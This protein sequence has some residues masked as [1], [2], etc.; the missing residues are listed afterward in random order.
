MAVSEDFI[1]RIEDRIAAVG[2]SDRQVSMA[3]TGKPDL[4]RDLKRRGVQP[5]GERL[6]RLAR[7][8]GTTSEWLLRGE[9]V[10][11]RRDLGADLSDPYRVFRH[12]RPRDVPVRGT[13]SCGDIEVDG[14]SVE[15]V[16]MDLGETVDY[17]RRPASLDGRRD[18]YAIYFTGYSM[19]PRFEQGEVA[20]V[21]TKRPPAIGDYVVVQLRAQRCEGDEPRIVQ[22][23]VKRLVKRTA[24][25]VE[26]EQFNRPL[27]FKIEQRRIASMHR[28]IPL[29]ELAGI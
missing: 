11:E 17:V 1:S 2:S 28:I 18:V 10:E 25:H 6:D 9:G 7:E 21:D 20:Y 23:L 24:D 16:D 5:S 15:T 8:L 29:A 27:I 3:V 26:L 13:P 14:E 4:I 19:E 22:A 12:E